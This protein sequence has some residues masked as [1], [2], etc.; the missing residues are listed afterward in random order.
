MKIKYL[1][2]EI[3]FTTNRY[4]RSND[5]DLS[6]A[7]KQLSRLHK[8]HLI[9]KITR[10]VWANINH[11]YFNPLAAVPYLLG[12]EQGYV[13]FLTALHYYGVI[14]QISLQIQ[15]A[16]TGRRRKLKSSIGYFDF[17]H[18][19]PHMMR[20]GIRWSESKFKYLVASPEKA[21]LDTLY[22]STRRGK[23]FSSL[24]E[25]DMDNINMKYFNKLM[26]LCIKSEKVKVAIE[27]C[28]KRLA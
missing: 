19:A 14:S 10:G 20:E 9:E 21:L 5:L 1:Q 16:T 24:P 25:L 4:A 22:I 26:K 27:R 23:R 12:E 6:S 7:A 15:I 3:V 17:I 8:N 2:E 28:I 18:L 13:S 11:P